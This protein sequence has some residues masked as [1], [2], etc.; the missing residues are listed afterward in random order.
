[1]PHGAPVAKVS[2]PRLFGVVR[3]E[4]LFELL[5]ANEGRP[6]VW[7]GGP[8][9][10][11]KT[12][13]VASYLEH[14]AVPNLWYQIDP[15]DS[16]PAAFFHYL[17]VAA[18]ALRKRDPVAVP[19]F[20]PEHW[21]NV[22]AFARLFFRALFAD[23]ADGTVLV[24]DNYQQLDANSAVH[25]AVQQAIREVPRNSSGAPQPPLGG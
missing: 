15:D 11:G 2:R 4:R 5:G 6:L 21:S 12:T 14:R 16:D 23:L 18:Q 3:R 8:P 24:L 1:M 17:I 20:L 13:L 10:A 25:Q 7:I 22:T 19:K 9:G